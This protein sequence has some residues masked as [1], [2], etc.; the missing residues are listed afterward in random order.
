MGKLIEVDEEV[1]NQNAK[2]RDRL[3][4]IARNPKNAA[5]LEAMEK[6]IDPNV[7][8]PNLDQQK[9]FLE[10]VEALRKDFA[11][12]KKG[13]EEERAKE[14]EERSKRLLT[15]KWEAGRKWMLDQG[16]TPEGI[17]KIEKELMA[18]KGLI[19][20]EDAAKIWNADHPAPPPAT[21]GGFGAWNF[22]DPPPTEDKSQ[23]S[24]KALVGSKGENELV[25]DRMARDALNEFRQQVAQSS[26]RR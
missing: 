13:Q 15:E 26:G 16:F 7:T 23:D 3:A 5:A 9:A 17:E 2:L 1:Y 6:E 25:A 10:P 8:T 12:F 18:P 19:D 24:I 20:H 21:P 14:Q 11:D 4:R 22:L